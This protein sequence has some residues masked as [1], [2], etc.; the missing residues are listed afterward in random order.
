M[1]SVW[2]TRLTETWRE[3]DSNSKKHWNIINDFA[4]FSNNYKNYRQYMKKLMNSN[5]SHN[6]LPYFGLYLRDLTFIEDGNTTT[7]DSGIF[8]F[9]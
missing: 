4:S 3:L 9:S 8:Y 6:V 2:I 7:T 5:S 1:S